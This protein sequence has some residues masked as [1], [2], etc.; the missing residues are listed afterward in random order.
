MLWEKSFD[1]CLLIWPWTY[2]PGLY[3]G[4]EFCAKQ[5]ENQSKDV[6]VMFRLQNFT[7]QKSP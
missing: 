2:R 5:Y 7:K 3:I 6:E 1:L 4:I